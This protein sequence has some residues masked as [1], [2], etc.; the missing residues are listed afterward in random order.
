MVEKNERA[1]KRDLNLSAETVG[2]LLTDRIP[3]P[4]FPSMPNRSD[5]IARG[6]QRNRRRRNDA[7]PIKL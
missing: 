5:A 1:R 2:I 6:I 3:L 7:G 4:A